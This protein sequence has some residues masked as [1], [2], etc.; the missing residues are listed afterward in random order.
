MFKTNYSVSYIIKSKHCNNII[1]YLITSITL[2][3]KFK[4]VNSFKIMF[5]LVISQIVLRRGDLTMKS[6]FTFSVYV[7]WSFQILRNSK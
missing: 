6:H 5:Y 1:K 3:S 4:F 7:A 2:N